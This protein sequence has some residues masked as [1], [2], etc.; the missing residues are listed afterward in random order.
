[1]TKDMPVMDGLAATETIRHV[2][3][4]GLVIGM[5]AGNNADDNSSYNQMVAEEQFLLASGADSVIKKPLD[6]IKLRTLPKSFAEQ[7]QVHGLPTIDHALHSS[8]VQY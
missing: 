6:I 5:T 7:Q 3:Y 4:K 1:M 8:S 2:G